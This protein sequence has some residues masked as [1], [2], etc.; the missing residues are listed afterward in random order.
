MASTGFVEG[1]DL[2]V[3]FNGT[4]IAYSK[5]CTLNMNL[6]NAET[7]NK[8]DSGWKGVLPTKRDWSVDGDGLYNYGGSVSTL[9]GLYNNRTRVSIKFSNNTP[10]DKYYSGYAYITKLQISGPDAETATY[11][12]SFA[13]DGQLSEYTVT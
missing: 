11:S 4:A 13:G 1:T 6:A 7:T 5:N 8:D 10:G 2:L 3:Y 9:F 12:F